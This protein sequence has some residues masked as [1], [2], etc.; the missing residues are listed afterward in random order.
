[1]SATRLLSLGCVL[2]LALEPRVPLRAQ[3]PAALD[4]ASPRT[5]PPA[6]RRRDAVLGGA[7]LL[8]IAAAPIVDKPV[9]RELLEEDQRGNRELRR[10]SI[11]GSAIG[12]V[13]P[14]ALSSSLYAAGRLAKRRR[15]ERLGVAMGEAVLASGAVGLAVKGVVGRERPSAAP[16]KPDILR[17]GQG[18]SQTRYASFPSGHT[19]AAFACATVLLADTADVPRAARRIV[20]PIGFAAAAFVG[21]SRIYRDQHWASDVAV[22][23][24]LGVVAGDVATRGRLPGAAA[25]ERALVHTSVLRTPRGVGV[26]WSLR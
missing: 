5:R 20:A 23:A 12:G 2:A 6:F 26:A 17:V 18:F 8:A 3:A 19:S 14:L 24:A 15:V 11:I 22:G 13:G 4:T 7:V 9:S 1:M 16:G 25:L 10:A 21:L